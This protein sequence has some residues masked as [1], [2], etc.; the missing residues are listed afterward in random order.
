MIDYTKYLAPIPH[1]YLTVNR[2]A[3]RTC[4]EK[5]T[6]FYR[7]STTITVKSAVWDGRQICVGDGTFENHACENE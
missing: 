6:L 7:I 5:A 2:A 4:A 3:I 1:T